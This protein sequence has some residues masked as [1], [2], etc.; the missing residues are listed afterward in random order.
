MRPGGPAASGRRRRRR[1]RT[2]ASRRSRAGR[3]PPCGALTPRRAPA[4]TCCRVAVEVRACLRNPRHGPDRYAQ[5]VPAQPR[6]H[7][8]PIQGSS[9]RPAARQRPPFV[10]PVAAA[11]RWPESE[12]QWA[13]SMPTRLATQSYCEARAWSAA[14][15][16]NGSLRPQH[17]K[18]N[19][20]TLDA[21][22][23]RGWALDPGGA[24]DASATPQ[25]APQG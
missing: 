19:A 13:P 5:A 16:Q 2:G 24:S 25:A 11:T 1:R 18:M 7:T 8:E 12:L 9:A 6:Q 3:R 15:D 20:L 22:P 14:D 17:V 21:C 23:P 4:S 10:T